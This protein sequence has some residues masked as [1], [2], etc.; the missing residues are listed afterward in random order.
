MAPLAKAILVGLGAQ[1]SVAVCSAVTQLVTL[2]ILSR[3]IEPADFGVL[4]SCSVVISF[5]NIFVDAGVAPAIV[6]RKKIS[7]VFVTNGLILSI[8]F[9]VAIYA[10]VFLMAPLFASVFDDGRIASVLRV[11]SL[12][13]LLLSFCLPAKALLERDLCFV[14][15]SRV[16]LLRSVCVAA[17]AVTFALH[18][19]GLWSVVYAHLGGSLIYALLISAQRR[20]PIRLEYSIRDLKAL[21]EFG[22]GLTLT[23]F[24]NHLSQSADLFLVGSVLGVDLLGYYERALKMVRMPALLLG[25]VMDR[26]SFPLFA[27]YQ[28]HSNL[29]IGFSRAVTIG[30]LVQFPA[31]ACI[32]ILAPEIVRLLLGDGWDAVIPVMRILVLCLPFRIMIRLT[33]ALVRA[34]GAVY[35]SALRKACY[36]IAVVVFCGIGTLWGIGGVAYGALSALIVNYVLMSLLSV[37][38]TA[39][40]LRQLSFNMF[41]GVVLATVFGCVCYF[42]VHYMRIANLSDS[43]VLFISLTW[44]SLLG[45]ILAL[46]LVMNIKKWAS[47]L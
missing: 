33:D 19:E 5:A 34:K 7:S 41:P 9:G 25:Q 47:Q 31:C 24:F 39:G 35:R 12:T 2:V 46:V 40:T 15:I 43:K 44:M 37:K 26:V 28:E 18:G 32:W 36:A 14:K 4:A 11:Q 22:G 20:Y 3:L 13:F 17:I 6:Q 10:L 23:R 1:G 38:L 8:L 45:G 27:R 42:S 30:Y 29:K 21:V 16:E